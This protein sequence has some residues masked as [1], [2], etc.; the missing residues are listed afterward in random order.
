MLDACAAPVR[1]LLAYPIAL[2]R[3]CFA[4]LHGYDGA[5]GPGWRGADKLPHDGCALTTIVEDA[6]A[7]DED[8]GSVA[9]SDHCLLGEH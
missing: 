4:P 5:D 6:D 3:G 7:D 1:M 8:D 9:G 2:I